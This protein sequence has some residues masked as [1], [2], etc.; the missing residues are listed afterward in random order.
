M[1]ESIIKIITKFFEK[2][3]VKIWKIMNEKNI[4]ILKVQ[5]KD[6][7]KV[8]EVYLPPKKNVY[9]VQHKEKMIIV[10]CFSNEKKAEEYCV[11]TDRLAILKLEV[12]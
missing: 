10:G 6:R 12:I 4:D 9:V 8:D 3:K 1:K 7:I 2:V 5:K 11:G